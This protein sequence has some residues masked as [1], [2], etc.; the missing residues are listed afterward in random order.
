MTRSILRTIALSLA[1]VMFFTTVV[2]AVPDNL[3]AAESGGSHI[4][5]TI[6]IAPTATT[7]SP[8]A[9]TFSYPRGNNGFEYNYYPSHGSTHHFGVEFSANVAYSDIVFQWYRNDVPFGEPIRRANVT[10]PAHRVTITLRNVNEAEHGGAWHLVATTYVNGAATFTDR[11]SRNSHLWVRGGSGNNNNG[12]NNNNNGGN[13]DV[14]MTNRPG[15][16]A[17]FGVSFTYPNFDDRL[18]VNQN[19]TVNFNIHAHITGA[20]RDANFSELRFEWLRNGEVWQGAGGT[21][22]IPA[23]DIINPGHA[24][25]RLQL[26]GAPQA[27]RGGVWQLRVLTI[28][29]DGSVLFT[30][31]THGVFLTT[32][33]PSS[34]SGGGSGGG[35][36]NGGSPGNGGNEPMPTPIPDFS[37]REFAAEDIAYSNIYESFRFVK[38]EI[39]IYAM[40]DASYGAVHELV[41]HH[42]GEI[43]GYLSVPNVYQVYFGSG[44][45]EPELLA[46]IDFFNAHEL[47][48]F[49]VL[50]LVSEMDSSI[51]DMP[52]YSQ[53]MGIAPM[54]I[55]P[56]PD[57]LPDAMLWQNHW[58]DYFQG[59]AGGLN[60]GVEAISAPSAWEY[61]SGLGREIST[62]TVGAVDSGF[63]RQHTN[64]SINYV[65]GEGENLSHGTSVMGVIGASANN[66]DGEN[67]GIIGLLWDVNL[68]GYT[69]SG[70]NIYSLFRK[71]RALALLFSEG[72]NIINVSLG[73]GEHFANLT[74]VQRQPHEIEYLIQEGL[75]MRAF[76]QQYVYLNHDFVI[77]QSAGNESR[78]TFG[79]AEMTRAVD[80]RYNG[81]FTNVTR[82]SFP[83]VYGRILIV[84]SMGMTT[85]MIEVPIRNS[86]FVR[87]P[88][89]SVPTLAVPDSAYRNVSSNFR[90]SPFS[91]LGDRVDILAPGEMILTPTSEDCCG[92]DGLGCRCVIVGGYKYRLTAGTSF[93]APHVAGVAGMIWSVNPELCGIAVRDTI[94]ESATLSLTLPDDISVLGAGADVNRV[95]GILNAYNAVT[96]ASRRFQGQGD[97][98]DDG[99]DDELPTVLFGR[100]T[101]SPHYPQNLRR[102]GVGGVEVRVYNVETGEEITNSSIQRRPVSQKIIMGNTNDGL[103]Y[104]IPEIGRFS[105]FLEPGQ[106]RFVFHRA[107][108]DAIYYSDIITIEYAQPVVSR[109]FNLDYPL[110]K[111]IH[112]NGNIVDSYYPIL[113]DPGS[114][115]LY[116]LSVRF[117]AE[118]LGRTVTWDDDLHIIEVY[119]AG[120]DTI[121][122]RVGDGFFTG[123]S[124]ITN[125]PI[126]PTIMHGAYAFLH[127]GRAFLR[128]DQLAEALDVHFDGPTEMPGSQGLFMRFYFRTRTSW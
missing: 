57:W 65:F 25:I 53:P 18:N 37:I 111:E 8:G 73:H 108:F 125:E 58:Y 29:A 115:G 107:G 32:R 61:M 59:K 38:G 112:I 2:A 96:S 101:H 12:G 93:F 88:F 48:V 4:S 46:L 31:Y 35:G 119:R 34:G 120:F 33:M 52:A 21:G 71:Q 62:V 67:D 78:T 11:T 6:G 1:A 51:P 42:D 23:S 127:E 80:A 36:N 103:I 24:G 84:G 72:S 50:N 77:I 97:D 68:Y 114:P 3:H 63:C 91:S 83:H 90:I 43:V 66:N 13:G 124:H 26:P 82:D 49:A 45:E 75:A 30:D 116:A 106:Y 98:D 55:A 86:A 10:S 100:V 54:A 5:R 121:W 126:N 99:D 79:G 118:Y 122:L 94:I 92:E 41:T 47:V 15:E 19:S 20:T 70:G 40:L 22:S 64:L 87:K 27:Q 110:T 123:H 76:L 85:D 28:G 109:Y 89:M 14:D 95:Y 104:D 9:L 113:Q 56:L 60:W 102:W 81:F 128:A 16:N 74:P 7:S 44:M 69:F 117:I 17:G 105:V 39:L